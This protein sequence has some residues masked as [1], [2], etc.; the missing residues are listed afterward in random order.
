MDMTSNGNLLALGWPINIHNVDIIK[1][2]EIIEFCFVHIAMI[3]FG[4]KQ[5]CF[6]MQRLKKTRWSQVKHHKQES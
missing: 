5:L 4:C 1:R 6:F 3:D 2:F